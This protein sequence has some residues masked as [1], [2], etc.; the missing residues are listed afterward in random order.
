MAL[1]LAALHNAEWTNGAG[2]M[3]E[4]SPKAT[5][6]GILHLQ[7]DAYSLIEYSVTPEDFECFLAIKRAH[8]WVEGR[9]KSV[10]LKKG[11]EAA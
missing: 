8:E 6:F 9:A 4:P 11:K 1:Q 10:V 5:R 7:D 2:D 3:L